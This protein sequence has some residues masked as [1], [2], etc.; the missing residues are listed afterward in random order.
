MTSEGLF[1]KLMRDT[2]R[3]RAA[4]PVSA[5]VFTAQPGPTVRPPMQAGEEGARATPLS[6]RNAFFKSIQFDRLSG[7]QQ[8]T[9]T[10][11][12]ARIERMGPGALEVL[13]P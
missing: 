10:R 9:A 7:T 5:S 11:L 4:L 2:N 6:T 1:T 3:R 8:A 12:V 13:A